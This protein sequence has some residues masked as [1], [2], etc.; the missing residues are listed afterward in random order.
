MQ[1]ATGTREEK[2][3]APSREGSVLE[4][5]VGSGVPK[6]KKLTIAD[7]QSARAM[8]PKATH[9]PP[10]PAAGSSAPPLWLWFITCMCRAK[11]PRCSSLVRVPWGSVCTMPASSELLSSRAVSSFGLV[12]AEAEA[13]E[14]SPPRAGVGLAAPVFSG[15]RATA[16]GRRFCARGE[17]AGEE[18]KIG[19]VAARDFAYT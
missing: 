13:G 4:H 8:Q 18:V 19:S 1:Q 17:G 16:L 3:P 10:L 7:C 12:A 15:S 2:P 14:A 11:E 5:T 6:Q 9:H